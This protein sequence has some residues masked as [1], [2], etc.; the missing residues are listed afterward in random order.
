MTHDEPEPAEAAPVDTAAE[1]P[2]FSDD[3]SF[4]RWLFEHP[5]KMTNSDK[6]FLKDL[7]RSSNYRDLLTEEGVDV[8][9]L[10]SLA[11]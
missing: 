10:K 11:A 1:R 6:A 8:A 7:L 2:R 3:V 9:A 5:D 4:G